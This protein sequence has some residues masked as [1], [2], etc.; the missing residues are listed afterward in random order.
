MALPEDELFKEERDEYYFINTVIFEVF[1]FQQFLFLLFA[2]AR[3]GGFWSF[4]LV[5]VIEESSAEEFQHFV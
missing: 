2:S 3:V 1:L 4:H 5:K